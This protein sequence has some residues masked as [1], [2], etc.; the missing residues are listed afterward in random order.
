[1]YYCPRF[2]QKIDIQEL[3]T[4]H[5]SEKLE[6]PMSIVA[7]TLSASIAYIK[8]GRIS[9]SAQKYK[10]EAHA[11]DILSFPKGILYHAEWSGDPV[12]EFY[13]IHYIKQ[14]MSQSRQ[15]KLQKI[16]KEVL[17]DENCFDRI[18]RLIQT[19]NSQ[20][21]EFKAVSEFYKLYSE[22]FPFIEF[23]DTY[24]STLAEAI[25]FIEINFREDFSVSKLA[26][27]CFISESRLYCLFKE[28]LNTT[29]IHFRTELRCAEAAKLLLDTRMTVEEIAVKCGFG[30]SNYF[31]EIFRAATSE[32]PTQF[33][34]NGFS[35]GL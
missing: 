18:H 13:S 25:K 14:P 27:H 26:A 11:G 24:P 4:E 7:K 21:D 15:T 12:L 17:S 5:F 31:R 33:R 35:R 30:S 22:L 32:S 34:K 28:Y 16:C 8:R 9:I 23:S 2:G 20:S 29:P 10:F 6:R 19:P 3:Q 1:M